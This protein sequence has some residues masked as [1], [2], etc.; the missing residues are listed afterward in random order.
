MTL[1]LKFRR[2][3]DGGLERIGDILTQFSFEAI[4]AS[5]AMLI[6]GIVFFLT[7]LL[8]QS[9]SQVLIGGHSFIFSAAHRARR[10]AVGSQVDLS[11][12]AVLEWKGCRG[13]GWL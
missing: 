2:K 4:L 13:L 1:G 9:Q 12:W 8:E 10:L 7:V 6:G 5:C 11:R 3:A